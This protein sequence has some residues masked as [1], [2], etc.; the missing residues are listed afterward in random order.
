MKGC[1]RFYIRPLNVD[2][3]DRHT[4]RREFLHPRCRE[5]GPCSDLPMTALIT[6]PEKEPKR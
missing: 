4:R 1:P 5:S 2:F 3:F 6:S